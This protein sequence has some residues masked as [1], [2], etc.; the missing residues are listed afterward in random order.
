VR[1]NGA[2]LCLGVFA[3]YPCAVERRQIQCALLPSRHF[4]Y[5]RGSHNRWDT[6]EELHVRK[7]G[8]T[9]EHRFSDAMPGAERDLLNPGDALVFCPWV[10]HRG[11]YLVDE[12]RRSLMFTYSNGPRPTFPG[13]DG[14]TNQ[15]IPPVLSLFT[16]F[17]STPQ[18]LTKGSTGSRGC[19]TRRT[20]KG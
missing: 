9:R 5:V 8:E 12:P 14:F 2:S 1:R 18:M 13:V 6:P 11:H 20:S 10:I 16:R 4:E 7:G 3:D 19:S 15:V 17:R